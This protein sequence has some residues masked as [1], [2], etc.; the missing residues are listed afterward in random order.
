MAESARAAV[1]IAREFDTL[2]TGAT[3]D[4]AGGICGA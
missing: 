1:S 4:I 3:L 2:I